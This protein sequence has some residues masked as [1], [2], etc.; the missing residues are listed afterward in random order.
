MATVLWC[1]TRNNG[2]VVD[3][4]DYVRSADLTAAGP[5]TLNVHHSGEIIIKQKITRNNGGLSRHQTGD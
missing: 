4:V 5:I 1:Y 2:F 3:G